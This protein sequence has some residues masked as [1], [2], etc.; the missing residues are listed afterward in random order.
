MMAAS[1]VLAS[2][3]ASALAQ[4]STATLTPESGPSIGLPALIREAERQNEAAGLVEER[5]E[6]ASA[7]VRRAVASLLPSAVLVGS[8]ANRDQSAR[9]GNAVFR[10]NDA[11]NAEFSVGMQVLDAPRIP[12]IGA[13]QS[14]RE[15]TEADGEELMRQLRFDVALGYYGV[16]VSEAARDAARE[17]LELARTTLRDITGRFEAGLASRNDQSRSELEVA[18]AR[19][20]LTR[21]D[22]AVRQARLQLGFLVGRPVYEAL[23]LDL[24]SLS[25]PRDLERRELEQAIDHRP[26]VRAIESR[27]QASER[28]ELSAWL[29]VVP[30]IGAELRVTASNETGFQEDPFTRIVQLTATWTLYDGG[31]RYADARERSARARELQLELSRLE[32]AVRRDVASAQAELEAALAAIVEA[33]EQVRV[34]EINYDEVRDRFRAG[35]ATA[36]EQADAATERFAAQVTLANARFSERQ[37]VLRLMRALGRSSPIPEASRS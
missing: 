7:G 31:V 2:V 24:S 13:A 20:A 1:M 12:E 3:V 18:A 10:A 30:T 11:L 25:A 36:V 15:A 14:E 29:R 21:T 34:A 6:Q 33:R 32:R 4:T 9:A 23:E 37:A 26:D 5:I 16:L 19:L 27:I 22:N 8:Y 17:R 28:S 35:V